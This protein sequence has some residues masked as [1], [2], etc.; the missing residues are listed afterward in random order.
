MTADINSTELDAWHRLAD[1]VTAA[2][3]QSSREYDDDAEGAAAFDG[4]S[5]A[6]EQM[7]RTPA[8]NLEGLAFKVGSLI[9]RSHLEHS[10]DTLSN[11]TFLR[12]LLD[13]RDAGGGGPLVWILKDA[14]RLA[15]VNS[16]VVAL[17]PSNREPWPVLADAY[18]EGVAAHHALYDTDD[19]PSVHEVAAS[20]ER[21]RPIAAAV[22]AYAPTTPAEL[23]EK[24]ELLLLDTAPDED[25]VVQMRTLAAD[26]RRL[27]AAA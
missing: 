5:G 9:E 27:A 7:M 13:E 16:P 12:R 26:A 6:W 20:H 21:Q 4:Y 18:R 17:M 11:L 3:V 15:G 22:M 1:A 25:N 23:A 10:D 14:L 19:E 24:A 2:R 8:P